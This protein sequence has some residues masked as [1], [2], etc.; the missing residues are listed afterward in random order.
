MLIA[1]AHWL[2]QDAL[3]RRGQ[4][5]LTF[6]HVARNHP[7]LVRDERYSGIYQAYTMAPGKLQ[8]LGGVAQAEGEQAFH[9]PIKPG[10]L[11]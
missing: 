3:E 4:R 2:L 7:G 9:N 11:P 8:Q 6:V 1:V 10:Q 5:N